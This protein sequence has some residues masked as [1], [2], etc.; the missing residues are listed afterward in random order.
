MGIKYTQT[1]DYKLDKKD[2]NGNY[3][4]NYAG[5]K[6]DENGDY[7]LPCCATKATTRK[8]VL[9]KDKVVDLNEIRK[10]KCYSQIGIDDSKEVVEDKEE[11][12]EEKEEIDADDESVVEKE[13]T[14]RAKSKKFLSLNIL[15]SSKYP[16]PFYRLGYLHLT[17]KKIFQND[18]SK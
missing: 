2:E 13:K 6:D 16:I 18:H 9:S 5:F 14:V 10:K 15:S 8:T 11:T 7:C 3:V 17:M 1:K 12:K 4:Y